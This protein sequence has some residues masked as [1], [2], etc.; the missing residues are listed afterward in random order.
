MGY[1]ISYVFIAFQEV[2]ERRFSLDP[3]L[4]NKKG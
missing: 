3:Y 4:R 2:L 1:Q